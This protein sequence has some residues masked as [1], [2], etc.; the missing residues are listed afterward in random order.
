MTTCAHPGRDRGQAFPLYIVLVVAMLFAALAFFVIGQASVT[1]SDAQGAADAAALAAAREAGEGGLI[2][3]DLGSLTPQ[4]WARLLAGDLLNGS[5][6]C[7]AAVDFAAKN[8]AVATCDPSFPRFDVEVRTNRTVGQSVIPGTDGMHGEARASATIEPLCVLGSAIPN[9]TAA[10]QPSA[11]A[12][13]GPTASP[14]PGAQGP[15]KVKVRCAGGKTLE[16][17]PLKPGPLRALSRS[18]F[19]VRLVE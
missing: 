5:G 13:A 7:A 15:G 3:L 1:R 8:D 4:E 6:A 11:T 12:T 18:L 19:K 2:A 14:E 16:I 9:P 17:D 10:P